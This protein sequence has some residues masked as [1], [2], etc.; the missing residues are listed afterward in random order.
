MSLSSLIGSALVL[1]CVYYNKLTLEL[2]NEVKWRDS[3]G[4]LS[5]CCD[6]MSYDIWVLQMSTWRMRACEFAQYLL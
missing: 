4:S 6:E 2:S 3:F 1:R 5:I